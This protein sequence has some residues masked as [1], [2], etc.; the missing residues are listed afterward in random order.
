MADQDD[1]I[2]QLGRKFQTWADSLSGDE[3]QV[4]AQWWSSKSGDDVKG[5]TGSWWES[6]EAWSSAWTESWSQWS[7]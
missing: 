1:T 5:Y 6:P 3:K 7:D 4:L 2:Q